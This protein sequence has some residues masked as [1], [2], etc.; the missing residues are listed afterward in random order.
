MEEGNRD[1]CEGKKGCFLSES[2]VRK[3]GFAPV[4]SGNFSGVVPGEGKGIKM[5]VGNL[6]RKSKVLSFWREGED[7]RERQSE[8]EVRR[9]FS[10]VGFHDETVLQKRDREALAQKISELEK[11]LYQYQH[12]MGLLLI[13][14]NELAAKAEN[15]TKQ[16]FEA[17]QFQKN[18]QAEHMAVISEFEKKDGNMQRAMDFQRQSI[19]NLEK[20]LNEMHV[21]TAEIKLEYQKKMSEAH[22]LEAIVEDK[23]FELKGKMDFLDAKL[24]EVSQRSSELDR[25]SEDVDTRQLKLSIES[26][27]FMIEYAFPVQRKEGIEK[28]LAHQRQVLRALEQEVQ[29]NQESLAKW[30]N[31]CRKKEKELDEAWKALENSNVSLKSKEEDM[32]MRLRDFDAKAQEALVKQQF[33]QNKEKEL[34]E[35][36]E[37]LT[38]RERV[39]AYSRISDFLGLSF[40]S[41]T[42]IF[43]GNFTSPFKTGFLYDLLIVMTNSHLDCESQDQESHHQDVKYSITLI[44]IRYCDLLHAS[45]SIIS[46]FCALSKLPLKV[47]I[48]K[49]IDCHSCVL[50]DK[51]EEFELE[52]DKKRKRKI[53]EVAHKD[54]ALEDKER[55]ILKKEQFLESKMQNMMHREE[56]NQTKI[57][58]LKE[59]IENKKEEL[60]QDQIKAEKEWELLGNSRLTLE[61]DLKQLCNEKEKFARQRCTEEETLKNRERRKLSLEE[62]MKQLHDKKERFAKQIFTDEEPLKKENLELSGRIQMV[63]ED[64]KL[65]KEI[66]INEITHQKINSLEVF[67]GENA[68]VAEPDPCLQTNQELF[69]DTLIEEEISFNDRSKNNGVLGSVNEV[70]QTTENILRYNE[71]QLEE[72]LK[73]GDYNFTPVEK[74]TCT[75]FEFKDGDDSV[76]SLDSPGVTDQG[77]FFGAVQPV[78]RM[79]C[80]QRCSRLLQ[81]SPDKRATDHSDMPVCIDGE[82]SGHVENLKPGEL[83]RDFN[84]FQQ[85]QFTSGIQCDT[86]P[87]RL[88][89]NVDPAKDSFNE[90]L[91]SP[92]LIMKLHDCL[93]DEDELWFPCAELKDNHRCL[94]PEHDSGPTQLIQ[95]ESGDHVRRKFVFVKKSCSVNALIQDNSLEDISKNK[96]NKYHRYKAKEIMPRRLKVGYQNGDPKDDNTEEFPYSQT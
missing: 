6:V 79:S 9:Q 17:Q 80:M 68:N 18:M 46:S 23:Y 69:K 10:E 65:N 15:L 55:E 91:G 31:T 28:E 43:L 49:I 78:A 38:N 81:L 94:L 39:S 2:L 64:S 60:I 30:N 35:I 76:M 34:L 32:C 50:Q 66:C 75:T 71:N 74:L 93:R 29:G 87:P 7:L 67:F 51:L 72:P 83:L 62:E 53:D 92:D 77:T 3:N 27:S 48:E 56:E 19:D 95:K 54:I 90:I 36:E 70:D 4:R 84:V 52:A 24:A 44:V 33:L 1:A 89:K 26:S 22:A 47:K 41:V 16:L 85:P 12:H 57:N 8:A 82:P 61:E 21:E 45:E 73:E 63:I 96:L 58:A 40:K 20:A 11:E 13:E 14:K 59:A 42:L 25:R 88:N 86:E 5:V 37:H